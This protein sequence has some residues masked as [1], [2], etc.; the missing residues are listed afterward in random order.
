[1]PYHVV[2]KEQE[3]DV[4]QQ[5]VKVFEKFKCLLVHEIGG[6]DNHHWH[7]WTDCSWVEAKVR[8]EIDKVRNVKS[9]GVS[10]RTWDSNLSYFCKGE[11]ISI[12]PDIVSNTTGI[13]EEDVRKLQQEYWTRSVGTK[14]DPDFKPIPILDE[15]VEMLRGKDIDL[16]GA[17]DAYL[18]IIIQRNGKKMLANK[19]LAQSY[20][21]TALLFTA[22]PDKYLDN[23]KKWIKS[24]FY[25]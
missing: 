18:Q 14:D 4:A 10:I 13:T 15:L 2:V 12:Y 3:K 17:I 24:G 8:R 5:L 6:S 22:N 16:D 11:S 1:M 21:R 23:T 7:F 20:I 9:K 25:N 19:P